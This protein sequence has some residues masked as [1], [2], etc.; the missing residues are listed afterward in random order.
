MNSHVRS[1]LIVQSFA[2]SLLAGTASAAEQTSAISRSAETEAVLGYEFSP[3]DQVLLDEIQ[4]G[5]FE[6]LWREVGSPVPLV[7]DRLTDNQVSSVAGVGFQLSSLPIGIE[8]GWISREQGRARA[9]AILGALMSQEDNKK[10]GIYLHYVDLNTG[11]MHFAEGPQVQASTIDHA[12]L[13]AGAMTAAV[14]FGGKVAGLATQLVEDANWKAYQVQP[15]GFISFGWRPAG[16]AHDLNAPGDFRPWTWHFASSEE[17]LVYF[18]AVGSPREAHAVEP[19]MYYR[20]ERVL[21]QH[22]EMKP[23]VVS[24]GSPAFTFFFS[25]CWI[26]YRSLGADNPQ[27]FGVDQPAVDWFENSRRAM[28]THRQRCLEVSGQFNTLAPNRWGMSPAADINDKGEIGY[29]VQSLRPNVEDKDNFCKGT[30]TPYAAGS[31]IMF[32][33]DLAVAAL[34]EFRHLK[35]SQGELVVWRDLKEGGYGLLDSFNLDRQTQQG[36]PDYLSIDEGP[37]LL[38]IENARSGLIWKLF[39]QHPSAKLAVERLKLLDNAVE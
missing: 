12:L 2:T 24:W 26:D 27:V 5:C 16:E 14:Y 29:I 18:L 35:N 28:L 17:Q 22:Q 36:T 37:M 1:I 21:K 25:Q 9:E 20:L 7:K 13:Q 34:H 38:A 33:P 39:M 15:D 4:R 6:F 19:K 8:R 11:G 23:F 31:A 32:L 30:V 3:A 10:H